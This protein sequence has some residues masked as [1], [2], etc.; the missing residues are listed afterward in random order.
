MK[1]IRELIDYLDLGVIIEEPSKVEGGLLHQMYCVK[2]SESS[3]AIKVINPNIIKRPAAYEHYVTSEAFCRKAFKKGLNAVAALEKNNEVIHKIN[4]DY[5]L[6]YPWQHGIKGHHL[7]KTLS[8]NHQV[9]SFLGQLHEIK[10]EFEKTSYEEM[11]IDWQ[12]YLDLS[13]HTLWFKMYKDHLEDFKHIERQMNN[14]MKLFSPDLVSHRDLDP[15]NTLWHNDE[16]IVIDWESAGPVNSMVELLEVALY[17]SNNGLEK[18]LFN[19]VLNAYQTYRPISNDFSK[20]LYCVFHGKLGWLE[21][22]IKRSLA[23]ESLNEE[24]QL[25]GTKQVI[26]TIKDIFTYYGM[27]TTLEQVI[28]ETTWQQ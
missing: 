21:Y 19:Q 7:T 1:E 6:V 27:I 10:E 18:D 8:S 4:N 28:K 13:R 3:Y 12:S 22:N 17:W 20:T 14:S 9:G 24:D 2:T 15:K 16:L 5:F 11:S 23:I 25:L 26:A